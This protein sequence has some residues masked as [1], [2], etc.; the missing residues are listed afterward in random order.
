MDINRDNSKRERDNTMVEEQVDGQDGEQ[1]IMLTADIVA[2]HVSNNRVAVND[3]PELIRQVHM[4]LSG[5][6]TGPVEVEAQKPEPAVSVRSSVKPDHLVCLACG[7][8][9]KMLRRHLVVAHGMTPEQYRAAYE[10]P[11]TYPMVAP[12]YSEQRAD[13]ARAIGLGKMPRTG[14]A[15]AGRKRAAAK[16]R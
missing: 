3:L 15:A 14:K 6:G 1:V 12:N 7:Q 13:L 11:K 9:N 2:A 10:L 16:G 5:L 4:A 8:K